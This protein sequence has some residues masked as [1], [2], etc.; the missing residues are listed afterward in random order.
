[1]RH[2]FYVHL[3]HTYYVPNIAVEQFALCHT[4]I[5]AYVL[6]TCT[7]YKC[8]RPCIFGGYKRNFSESYAKNT[9]TQLKLQE[10]V[11]EISG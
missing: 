4:Y 7:M 6:Q 1:M 3:T 5:C 10:Y 9:G 11:A 2:T 8:F